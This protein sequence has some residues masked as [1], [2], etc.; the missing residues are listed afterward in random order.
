M[1]FGPPEKRADDF[2]VGGGL[3][4]VVQKV[5]VEDAFEEEEEL[6]DDEIK[7]GLDVEIIEEGMSTTSES[8]KGGVA[9]DGEMDIEIDEDDDEEVLGTWYFSV[10]LWRG[11]N[12][13]GN[14][15][16]G[17]TSDP[18]VLVKY[19]EQE[20]KSRVLENTLNPKWKSHLMFQYNNNNNEEKNKSLKKKNVVDLYIFDFEDFTSDDLLGKV[21]ISLPEDIAD[22]SQGE[23]VYPILDHEWI[24]V[25]P[26]MTEEQDT[27]ETFKNTVSRRVTKALRVFHDDK[28]LF[29]K[30]DRL[31]SIQIS[32]TAFKLEEL[33]I[34]VKERE[35][36][37]YNLKNKLSAERRYN[38]STLTDT[39][40]HLQAELDAARQDNKILQNEL[41]ITQKARDNISAELHAANAAL[42][43]A[44]TNLESITEARRT[45]E[46]EV[47]K[48]R[49]S[50]QS[51]T[52]IL[53]DLQNKFKQ[54]QSALSQAENERDSLKLSIRKLE[55]QASIKDKEHSFHYDKHSDYDLTISELKERIQ[56]LTLAYYWKLRAS[57]AAPLDDDRFRSSVNK[58]SLPSDPPLRLRKESGIADVVV[59]ARDR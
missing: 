43:Q 52:Q 15:N 10:S 21:S 11:Q 42:T 19:G 24:H 9:I 31:G 27:L 51:D 38:R 35:E 16:G 2:I 47:S 3:R 6:D 7:E 17:T 48:L 40:L 32:I 37:I 28:H 14:N 53:Q 39:A 41:A 59:P 33:P 45:L 18:Y 8:S 29:K 1:K 13:L 22:A 56:G 25:Q 50:A 26:C 4:N 46:Q 44:T 20:L 23:P 5:H 54:A 49:H 55:R 34:L 12:L 57:P 30:I 58:Y 36:T